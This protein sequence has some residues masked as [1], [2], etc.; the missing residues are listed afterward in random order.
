VAGAVQ[1]IRA[2]AERLEIMDK[3]AGILAELLYTEK[4]LTQIKEYRAIMLHFVLDNRKGQKYLLSAFEIL[5]G[6]VHP[7]LLPRVPHILK[8]FY[9]NDILEEEA[10]LEWADRVSKKHVKKETSREI[11]EKA[12]PFV[13]WL[14]TAEEESSDE[15]EENEVEVVYSKNQTGAS[16]MAQPQETPQQVTRRVSLFLLLVGGLS[17]MCLSLVP[18]LLPTARG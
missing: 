11:H 10:I 12:A 4:L 15:E 3:A 2:E 16:I 17:C 14:R 7:E 8:A 1:K 9:D 6:D 18:F 5:V 13:D